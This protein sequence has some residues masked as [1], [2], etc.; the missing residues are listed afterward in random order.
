MKS[1]H[2]RAVLPRSTDLATLFAGVRALECTSVIGV[3]NLGKSALLR[4]MTDGAVQTQHLGEEAAN[5]LFIY[6][7]FN[8]M[9]EM[10][11]QAFYELVLRCA[12]DALR[13]LDERTDGEV[14]R[15]VESAYTG[16]IAPAS[17]FEVPLRFAQAMAAI[18]DL[19]PQRGGLSAG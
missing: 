11:E 9:L 8:Q 16:L 6:I 14:L 18:G 10:T 12:L 13:V 5:Y 4:S 2:A 17:S 1:S 7:D 19:L 15:R 3:S